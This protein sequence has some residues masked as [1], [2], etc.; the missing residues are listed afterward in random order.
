MMNTT[1]TTVVHVLSGPTRQMLRRFPPAGFIVP[2]R[3]FYVRSPA[4]PLPFH[5]STTMLP[6]DRREYQRLHLTKP[7]L[8]FA[9]GMNALILDLGVSGALIEHYGAAASGEQLQLSFRWR[10]KTIEYRCEVVRSNVVRD[11]GGDGM[12]AVSHTGL[13][14]LEGAGDSAALLKDLIAT[15]VGRVLAAQRANAAGEAISFSAGETVLEQLG[16]ARRTRTSGYLTYRLKDGKWWRIPT[17]SHV[18]PNDGFTVAAYEDEE[19]VQ[20]LC[21]AYVQTDD[22][23]QRLIRLV[24]ELSVLSAKE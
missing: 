1:G 15:F 2:L 8:A 5:T 6:D 23:G 18:Q 12:H 16:H 7:I 22:E 24:A 4:K 17:Q 21:D 11:P 13:R 19:E 3:D 20:A 10:G 9:R 14:F